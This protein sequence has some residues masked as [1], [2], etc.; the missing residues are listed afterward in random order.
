MARK[1]FGYQFENEA[2]E[3]YVRQG[4][5]ATLWTF[6]GGSPTVM[7][8][9]TLALSLLPGLQTFY[10]NDN[11]KII[12]IMLQHADTYFNSHT[13]GV[14]LIAGIVLAM[15]K[16]R[17]RNPEVTT[18]AIQSIKASLMGPTAG[19]G[20]SFYFN[21]VRVIAASIGISLALSQ[22]NVTNN[23]NDGSPLGAFVFALIFGGITLGSKIGFYYLGY[24]QG[25]GFVEKAF[26]TGLIPLLS[27]ASTILG[28]V[29]VGSLVA[30]NVK[31]AL[32]LKPEINGSVV[33]IQ[34]LLDGLAP[35][36]LSLALWYWAFTRLQKGWSPVKLIWVIMLGCVVLTAIGIL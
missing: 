28:C 15:E 9:K 36:I 1:I 22:Y 31:V 11:E 16:E 19:I 26:A 27:K 13:V 3:K 25:V 32:A 20:D 7:Q 5:L 21:C 10:N 17:A 23:P 33:D 35:G 14:S 12:P 6:M 2:E 29:M 30:S 34:K 4:C 8:A 24:T 18:E